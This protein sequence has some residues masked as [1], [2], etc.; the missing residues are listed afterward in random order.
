VRLQF[1][2]L[3]DVEDCGPKVGGGNVWIEQELACL[4]QLHS[5]GIEVF[6]SAQPGRLKMAKPFGKSR[7]R[8]MFT[9]PPSTG[10]RLHR[11]A[12]PFNPNAP[13]Q[14]NHFFSL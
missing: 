10:W 1:F 9:K 2:A 4:S 12:V 8:S 11:K 3:H 14:G 6:N 5:S 7:E 13:V